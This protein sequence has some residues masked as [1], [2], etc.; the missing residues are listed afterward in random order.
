MIAI[1]QIELML[2][3][4]LLCVIKNGLWI[5]EIWKSIAILYPLPAAI[6][7]SRT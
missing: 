4:L 5:D 1:V 7:S 3:P 6:K 2:R